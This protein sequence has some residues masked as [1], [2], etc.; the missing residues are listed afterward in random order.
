M[1]NP[2]ICIP[3]DGSGF[4][5]SRMVLLVVVVVFEFLIF[6]F[7]LFFFFFLLYSSEFLLRIKYLY[8]AIAFFK[9][10]N[11]IFCYVKEVRVLSFSADR[12]TCLFR[13]GNCIIYY[14]YMCGRLCVSFLYFISK[15]ISSIKKYIIVNTCN[16]PPFVC[17]TGF[18]KTYTAFTLL[19]Q[20]IAKAKKK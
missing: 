16:R 7:V 4:I 15:L 14:V 8:K 9:L 10:L 13:S 6:F 12:K 11:R 3:L 2:I 20:S 5:H 19:H 1:H 17:L 18:L